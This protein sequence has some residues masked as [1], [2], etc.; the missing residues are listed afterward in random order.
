MNIQEIAAKYKQPHVWLTGSRLYGLHNEDSD[1]DYTGIHFNVSDMLNPFVDR[2]RTDTYQENSVTFHSAAKF[3]RLLV[4]GNP[5]IVD[6]VFGEPVTESRW[7]KFLIE[8]VKP[9]VVTQ[10]LAASYMGYLSEQYRRGFKPSTPQNPQRKEQLEELGYD[11]KY[12]MHFL[13]LAYTLQSMVITGEYKPL[14]E[15]DR[16]FLMRVR[17]GEFSKAN[18]TRLCEGE[19]KDTETYYHKYKDKLPTNEKLREVLERAFSIWII[20]EIQEG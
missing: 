5:N 2:E 7:G 8:S 16:E 1:Y 3:A 4:K 18:I 6:L 17:R 14:D 19:Y 10:Q 12:V 20:T 15:T 13:R 11:A 9:H